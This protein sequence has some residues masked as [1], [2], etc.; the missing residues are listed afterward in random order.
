MGNLNSIE[1]KQITYSVCGIFQLIIYVVFSLT[2]TENIAISNW[3]ILIPFSIL[4]LAST[5]T[6]ILFSWLVETDCSG[7]NCNKMFNNI[8][9][10]I[11]PILS[12][13]FIIVM[14]FT[15]VEN[16]N[17]GRIT[18]LV[19]LLLISGFWT[20]FATDFRGIICSCTEEICTINKCNEITEC[21]CLT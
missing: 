5:I 2:E 11:C 17:L 14:L 7:E 19:G 9:M 20:L 3:K 8:V 4:L 1:S 15:Q 21:T 6:P 12:F 10:T 13:I 18:I 16:N